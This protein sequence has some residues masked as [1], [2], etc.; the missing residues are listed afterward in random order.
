MVAQLGRDSGESHKV[1]LR[2]R[3]DVH[4]CCSRRL[5]TAYRNNGAGFRTGLENVTRWW[6]LC[7]VT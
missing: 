3:A 6:G 2:G 7:C 1:V 5:R 4:C